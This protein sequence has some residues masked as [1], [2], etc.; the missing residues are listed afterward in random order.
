MQIVARPPTLG[1]RPLSGQQRKPDLAPRCIFNKVKIGILHI[2][3]FHSLRLKV[4]A[5]IR[6]FYLSLKEVRSSRLEL[7]D[8]DSFFKVE[9]D[10]SCPEALRFPRVTRGLARSVLH[11]LRA[12]VPHLQADGYLAE[13]RSKGKI[14]KNQGNISC[15]HSPL[16][17]L[18]CC[19]VV[20]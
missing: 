13:S 14:F 11:S 15:S 19:H 2:L 18:R 1:S 12:Q 4:T 16:N 20:Y 8:Q 9:L 10:S 3:S 17:F 7:H 5:K 6:C